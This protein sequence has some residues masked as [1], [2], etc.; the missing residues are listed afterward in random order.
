MMK[1][2]IISF[3][4][5][6]CIFGSSVDES[7]RV[8]TMLAKQQLIVVEDSNKT[9]EVTKIN[10]P[11]WLTVS[12]QANNDERTSMNLRDNIV[13]TKNKARMDSNNTRGISGS[14][15]TFVKKDGTSNAPKPKKQTKQKDVTIHMS[16]ADSPKPKKATKTVAKNEPKKTAKPKQ[17][18]KP[19]PKPKKKN[20][21]KS[22]ETTGQ[23]GI[24]GWG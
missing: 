18:A 13:N 15:D 6:S 12:Y 10:Y 8:I 9:K 17:A 7:A 20:S 21:T 19:A 5:L 22:F 23:A 14:V 4:A 2:A 1:L 3:M 24:E 11:K 16:K